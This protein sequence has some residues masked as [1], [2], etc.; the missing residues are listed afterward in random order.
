MENKRGAVPPGYREALYWKLSANI[1]RY[2]GINLLSIPLAALAGAIFLP[3]GMWAG[4]SI[5]SG[6]QA[7]N[8][9]FSLLSIVS[10]LIFHELAHG[11]AM[12]TFGAKPRYGVKASAL[13]ATASGYAFTRNQYLIVALAPL[14]SLSLLALLGILV[15]SK[16][17]LVPAFV[18]G[19]VVNA[20]G[21]CGDVYMGW[22][23]ARYPVA[24]YV[25]DEEDGMRVFLPMQNAG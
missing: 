18:L 1:W 22:L 12:M 9:F 7:V 15:F 6:L 23:T 2:L 16:T 20:A 4:A 17:A 19:A 24:A 8:L 13:Y 21:A 10:T 14:V 5:G 3:L 11:L 25:I